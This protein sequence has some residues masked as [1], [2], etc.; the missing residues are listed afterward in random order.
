MRA[1]AS[2]ASVPAWPPPTTMQPYSVGYCIT[3][4]SRV[5]TY[6]MTTG[7]TL[8]T[9]AQF[10]RPSASMLPRRGLL[11]WLCALVALGATPFAPA[12]AQPF[13]LERCRLEAEGVPAA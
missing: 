12:L 11:G 10:R 13:A 3:R 4:D 5:S 6:A 2:A 9:M 7:G 1:A 8:A